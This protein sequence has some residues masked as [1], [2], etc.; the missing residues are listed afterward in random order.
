MKQFKCIIL[1]ICL[2]FLMGC[3]STNVYLPADTS[4]LN[5]SN[6]ENG[7]AQGQL[8]FWD[9]TSSK[10]T[11]TET[12]EMFWDDTNKRLGIGTDSPVYKLDV[13]GGLATD[14]I[15]SRIGYNFNTVT[16]A[17]KIGGYTLSSGTNLGVG[18]YYYITAFVTST[19]V[20][21]FKGGTP[22]GVTTTTGNQVVNL[23]GI[24]VSTD[25]DVIARKLYRTKV[26]ATNDNQYYLTT[27]NNNVD[28]TYTDTTPDV[29][30][31]GDGGQFYKIDTTTKFITK[32][33]V[34]SMILDNNLVALGG[35][36]GGAFLAGDGR[37]ATRTTLVGY[38]AGRY[39][40]SGN[41]NNIFGQAGYSL[42]T[43][44]VNTI[45][46][47]LAAASAISIYGNTIV[48]SN[49]AR[50]MQS[51]L[52]TLALGRQS[53]SYLVDG[54]T[55]TSTNYG[56]YLG[57]NVK[58]LING[59]TNA[60]VIGNTAESLGSNAIVLGNSNN[61]LT[62]LF[63]N[64]GIGTDTPQNKLDVA[65]AAVIGSSYAG[66][67]TAPTDGLLVEG[68]VGIGTTSPTVKLDIDGSLNQENG[69]ATINMIY[70]EM[71]I[72]ESTPTTVS[73]AATDVYVNIL[74]NQADSHTNGFTF[75]SGKL[76]AQY[77]GMYKVDA[78]ISF[79]GQ[80]GST[81]GFTFG[82]NGVKENECYTRRKLGSTDVGALAVTCIFPLNAG[83]NVTLMSA[84]EDATLNN[85][86]IEASNMNILRV[87]N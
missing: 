39:I 3:S 33:G 5:V 41:G 11:Y 54:S 86:L 79:S 44:S 38:N 17:E 42:T 81:H 82:F 27:I 32:A 18:L 46:G 13:T 19:G 29:S 22:L 52:F 51:G 49:T 47:D 53:A 61:I 8:N 20:S 73:Y 70:G 66:V 1:S 35:N 87:G 58:G 26:G 6:I 48:G 57:Y 63:G 10:W 65:G 85:I 34:Q 72:N 71:F 50:F 67:N 36:A 16:P 25:P 60:I 55:F 37:P 45:A 40:T 68:S 7:T 24:P 14:A 84:D 59:E 62:R 69:N 80:T 15:S 76:T 77:S 74:T 31:T 2:L 12:S 78:S 64:V 56:T 21:A 23:V 30:L 4:E 83:D 28:T 43:G 75:S 9:N